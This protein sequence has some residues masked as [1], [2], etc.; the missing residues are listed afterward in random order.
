M[1][2]NHICLP[3]KDN[4]A[5]F[6]ITASEYKVLSL[7]YASKDCLVIE[8][9]WYGLEINVTHLYVFKISNPKNAHNGG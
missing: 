9:Q 5:S 3:E 2:L 8:F 7:L 6:Q 1:Q 4:L